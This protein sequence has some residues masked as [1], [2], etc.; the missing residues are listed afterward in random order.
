MG[1]CTNGTRAMAGQYGGLQALIQQKAPKMIWTHYLIHQ[2]FLASQ[3]MSS[4]G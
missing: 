3:N 4:L 2:E 1:V